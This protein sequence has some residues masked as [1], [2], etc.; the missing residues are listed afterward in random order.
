[1]NKGD[2]GRT[3]SNSLKGWLFP[4]AISV[5]AGFVALIGCT[6]GEASVDGELTPAPDEAEQ[7]GA[8][9]N[10]PG[11]VDEPTATGFVTSNPVPSAVLIAS[12]T[13]TPIAVQ[14]ATPTP[15]AERTAT[16][17]A[18]PTSTSTPVPTAVPEP[19]PTTLLAPAPVT[20]PTLVPA[21]TPTLVPAPTPVPTASPSPTASPTA[22][23]STVKL[24]PTTPPPPPQPTATRA[25]TSTPVPTPIPTLDPRYGVA[26]TSSEGTS[27]VSALG[28]ARYLNYGSGT[29]DIPPGTSKV[30]YLRS[31]T[32]VPHTMIAAAAAAA[33]GSTWYVLGEPNVPGTNPDDIVVG[34]HDTY[35]AIRSNDPTAKITSP[36]ILNFDFTCIACGGYQSGHYWID[37]F[38]DSYQSLYGVNPPVDYWAIDV[39][40]IVWDVNSLPTTRADIV[41]EQI[42]DFREYLNTMPT[43]VSKPIIVTEIGLHWGFEGMTFDGSSCGGAYPTG[44]YMTDDV[45][46]YLAEVFNWLEANSVSHNIDSWY[47]FSTYRDLS[48]CHPDK[49]YGLTLFE[50]AAPGSALSPVGSFFYDWIRGTRN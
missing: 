17:G 34:L 10:E 9:P 44:A 2:A 30:L 49:G 26:A 22:L 31:V 18:L 29:E 36:S 7:V 11:D 40:P 37:L 46:G 16:P 50:T 3:T 47:L 48:A 33:P 20:T 43:E 6:N 39:Y 24:T 8:T 27:Q 35:A 41:I 14:I 13:P 38:I 25:P 28:V 42:E 4:V 21:P 19:T 5:F 12:P 23:P 1:M 45:K 32:P 15:P